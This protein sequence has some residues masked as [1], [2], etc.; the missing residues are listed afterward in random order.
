VPMA[1]YGIQAEYD[2]WPLP[3][4]EPGSYGD[5]FEWLNASWVYMD[6]ATILAAVVALRFYPFPFIAAIMA[7]AFWFLSMDLTPWISYALTGSDDFTWSLRETVSM[8]FGAALIAIA[9]AL[10]LKRWRAGDFAFWLHL[11]GAVA[12]WGSLTMQDSD[13]GYLAL[14]Y[15]AI[16]VAMV[17][18]SVYF[19]RRIYAV[20]GALGISFYLGYLAFDVFPDAFQFSL[21]LSALGLGVIGLGIWYFRK[22]TEIALWLTASLPPLLQRLRPVHARIA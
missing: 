17:L 2:L 10:D 11:A 1:V 12:F 8:W 18:L 4:G 3:F 16:N 5:F 15:C 13:N 19:R 22:Q 21:A 7:A 9:W 14:L 20:F 6:I